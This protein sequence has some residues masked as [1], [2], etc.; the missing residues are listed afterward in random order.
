[1]TS[2]LKKGKTKRNIDLNIDIQAVEAKM[3][4]PKTSMPKQTSGSTEALA[5]LLNI[6]IGDSGETFVDDNKK[7]RK[8]IVSTTKELS[9]TLSSKTDIPCYWDAHKF[10]T[11]P[12]GCPIK[13]QTDEN[14]KH[15]Y[16]TDGIFCSFPCCYSFIREKLRTRGES[17]NY[18]ESIVLLNQMY[19]EIFGKYP[20]KGGIIEA[21]HW[22]LIFN[23]NLTIEAYRK[24]LQETHIRFTNNISVPIFKPICVKFEE[25]VK[26]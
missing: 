13:I 22:R 7:T 26:F 23:G 8:I 9:C 5:R 16:I 12:I 25:I 11:L 10:D 15:C 24:S 21:P 2:F 17:H 19:Y 6:P 14:G 4:L 18:R 20:P 1:M 3:N